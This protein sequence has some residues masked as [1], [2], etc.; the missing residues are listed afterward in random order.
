[1]TF[2]SDAEPVDTMASFVEVP[3]WRPMIVARFEPRLIYVAADG[4]QVALRLFEA[5]LWDLGREVAET[6]NVIRSTETPRC[7]CSPKDAA[8]PRHCALNPNARTDL[9]GSIGCRKRT[10]ARRSRLL[11]VRP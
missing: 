2:E 4:R 8:T 5:D 10:A 7:S 3:Q 11:S 9:Y 1:V 6:L